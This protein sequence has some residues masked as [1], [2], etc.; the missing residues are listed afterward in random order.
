MPNIHDAFPSN[1]LKAS[2]L[3]GSQPVATIDRVEIE[4]VGR[5]KEMK[6]VVYFVGKEKGIVL[7]KTNANTISN[8][9][10]SPNTEDWAG[11]AVRLYATHVEFG[12][13]QVEAI[14]IKSAGTAGQ[15]QN[16][17]PPAAPAPIVVNDET[18]R[19][20]RGL[21][22]E[23]QS[24]AFANEWMRENRNGK[25]RFRE[26]E[27]QTREHAIER[28]GSRLREMMPWLA[29]GRLVDKSRN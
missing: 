16:A 14:R 13:E 7:N 25:A 20:M 5:Q 21:L 23:I 10:G 24:G 4:P 27:S 26:L 17:M 22:A 9:V 19:R 29:E 18:R 12:G 1:Y 2:D 3:K 15:R 28:V 8:L 11:F 6:P